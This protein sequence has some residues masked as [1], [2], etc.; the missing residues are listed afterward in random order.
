[1]LNGKVKLNEYTDNIISLV[2]IKEMNFS[3]NE[4]QSMIADMVRSFGEK[5]IKPFSKEWDDN[6]I[7]QCIFLKN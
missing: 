6:Q 1:M 5:H 7:F 4:N 3:F 2:S